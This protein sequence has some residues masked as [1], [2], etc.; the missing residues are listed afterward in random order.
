ME[1]DDEVK[2]SG[3]SYD[4]GARML[5]PRIG[6]WL[7]IDPLFRNQPDQSPYKAFLNSPIIFSDPDGRDEFIRIQFYNDKG[8]LTGTADRLV[9]GSSGRYMSGGIHGDVNVGRISNGYNYY[10][11]TIKVTVDSEGKIIKKIIDKTNQIKWNDG[12]LD[13]EYGLGAEEKGSIYDASDETYEGKGSYQRGGWHL[14]SEDGGA[15]PTKTKSK[16]IARHSEIGAFLE[17]LGALNVGSLGSRI[18][19]AI[20]DAATIVEDAAE[21]KEEY[22]EKDSNDPIITPKQKPLRDS[23]VLKEIQYNDSEGKSRTTLHS[24]LSKKDAKT[25]NGK[26]N[27]GGDTMTVIKKW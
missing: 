20:N 25:Y 15:S 21:V 22:G 27:K 5:D 18:P 16:F 13:R 10:S 17:T 8:Q 11:S 2:G 24:P 23:I 3:N 12:I 9:K 19:D 26:M 7:T 6:R 1:K 4:F 14:T